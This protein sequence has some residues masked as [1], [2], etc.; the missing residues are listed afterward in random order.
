MMKFLENTRIVIAVLITIFI[1]FTHVAFSGDS[2]SIKRKNSVYAQLL[3]NSIVHGI[4]YERLLTQVGSFKLAA[5]LGY[6]TSMGGLGEV[7]EFVFPFE[8][9]MFGLGQRHQL[10]M[11]LGLTFDSNRFKKYYERRYIVLTRVGY[12]YSGRRGALFRVGFTP[13]VYQT[14]SPK[15]YRFVTGPVGFIFI[16]YGG[17]SLGWRF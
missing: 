11:G 4:N 15:V 8:I 10:E 7:D 9:K 3:G 14:F 13:H 5:S 17:V 1:T 6:A 2:V 12:R 16:P